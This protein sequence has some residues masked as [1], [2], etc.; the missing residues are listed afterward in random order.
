MVRQ[1]KWLHNV[2]PRLKGATIVVEITEKT[3]LSITLIGV[4]DGLVL[5]PEEE[6]AIGEMSRKIAG[7]L[8]YS[9]ESEKRE[10]FSLPLGD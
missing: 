9:P 4:I 3:G 8:G 7:M 2:P 10:S 6:V 5:T 1:F